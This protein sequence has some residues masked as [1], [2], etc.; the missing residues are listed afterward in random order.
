MYDDAG[1]SYKY[2]YDNLLLHTSLPVRANRHGV[3]YSGLGLG[4]RV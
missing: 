4:P 3:G 1:R 2:S